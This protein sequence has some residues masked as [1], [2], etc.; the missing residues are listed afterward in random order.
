MDLRIKNLFEGV[1]DPRIERT[2]K[3]PL[4]RILFIVL[5]GTLAGVTTG[6]GFQ[7]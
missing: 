2:K 6:S 4:E 7:D 3:H 1:E 5:C